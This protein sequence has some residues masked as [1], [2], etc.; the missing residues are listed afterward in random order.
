L[1]TRKAEGELEREGL[2]L[3]G[4]A[5]PVPMADEDS[6][7]FW[8]A[9]KHH[10]LVIQQCADCGAYRFAPAP[11]CYNCCS[12]NS[13]PVESAGFG[14]IYTW[15]ITYRGFHPEAEP[16]VPYNT[17][18]VRLLDC[19]GAMITTNIVGVENDEIYAGMKV[20][21][22]WDDVSDEISVPRFAP[23]QDDRAC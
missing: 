14:E 1:E 3:F 2:T 11:V 23:V 12:F 15:T 9:C 4:S 17:A 13:R 16:V 18:V 20:R 8:E 5:M 19:G 10:Q 6:R 21:V 22:E 7:E